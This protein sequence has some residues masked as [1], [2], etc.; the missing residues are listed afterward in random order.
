MRPE[1]ESAGVLVTPPTAA[2][3]E[4]APADAGRR[5]VLSALGALALARTARAQSAGAATTSTL[6]E[7]GDPFLA[8]FHRATQGFRLPDWEAAQALGYEA[9]LD[10]QL[11]PETID[12]SAV[13][14]KLAPLAS[15]GM[16]A[17]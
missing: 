10:Q 5:V 2:E 3:V 13:A 14:A 12:D 6:Q 8:L 15:L 11:A 16:S 7:R 4:S 17:A 1:T 9:W